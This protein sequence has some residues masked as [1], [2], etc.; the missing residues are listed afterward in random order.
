[1]GGGLP[2]ADSSRLSS[3]E[4]PDGSSSLEDPDPLSES[5]VES[6]MISAG[7]LRGRA[8]CGGVR[9]MTIFSDPFSPGVAAVPPVLLLMIFPPPCPPLGSPFDPARDP[10]A[11]L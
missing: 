8:P 3:L 1:M 11:E 5:L 9:L 6:T 10:A 7:G 2:P 4:S